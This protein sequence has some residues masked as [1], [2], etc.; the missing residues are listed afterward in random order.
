MFKYNH[1]NSGK[2]QQ[3]KASYE[4]RKISQLSWGQHLQYKDIALKT[5]KNYA[6]WWIPALFETIYAKLTSN[7]VFSDFPYKK[8]R[9]MIYKK[10]N[11]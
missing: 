6:I 4:E 7:D 8:S 9:K 11:Y 1:R 3:K 10:Y 5:Q 2:W